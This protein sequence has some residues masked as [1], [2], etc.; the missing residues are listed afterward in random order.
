MTESP[1]ISF[2]QPLPD[3]VTD[4][5]PWFIAIHDLPDEIPWSVNKSD[6]HSDKQV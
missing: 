4:L 2:Y 1:D 3:G 5:R 6:A